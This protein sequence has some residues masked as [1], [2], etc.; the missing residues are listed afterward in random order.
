MRHLPVIL[1]AAAAPL[2]VP[3]G[4]AASDPLK[5]ALASPAQGGQPPAFAGTRLTVGRPATATRTTLT[6]PAAAATLGPT[7]HAPLQ[8]S[9]ILRAGT[10]RATVTGLRLAVT[11]KGLTLSGRTGGS[12]V[13]VL[14]SRT[15][16]AA[17]AGATQ[18][19]LRRAA[20]KLTPAGAA[21]LGRQLRRTMRAG[22]TLGVVSGTLRS[23]GAPGDRAGGV[24]GHRGRTRGD[25][26]T[27]R[28]GTR[29]TAGH[30]SDPA[31]HPTRAAAV[32]RPVRRRMPRRNRLRRPHGR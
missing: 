30:T 24:D 27:V 10:R 23:A 20:L 7:S 26:D 22:T 12:T 3:H 18:L 17:P 8:G 2:A 15:G 19:R 28:G 11:A 21:H 31:G 16:T 6:L 14:T 5:I 1:L 9:L 4:A 25:A 13:T 29:D 32:Q